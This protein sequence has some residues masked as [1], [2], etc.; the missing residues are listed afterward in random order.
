LHT[1]AAAQS[2]A[3]GINARAY[4]HRNH[5]AFAPGEYN[6]TLEGRRLM[7]HELTHTLQQS[8]AAPPVLQRR[9]IFQEFAGLFAGETFSDAELTEYLGVITETN[10]IQDYTDSDNKARALTTRLREG[11]DLFGFEDTV[12]L[13][14]LLILEMQ[15]GATLGGD[16]RS[17]LYLMTSLDA[18][19]IGQLFEGTNALS[20]DDL[21]GDIH[22]DNRETL[23]T[24]FQ[25]LGIEAEGMAVREE[26]VGC[27]AA[28]RAAIAEA[29][30]LSRA[31]IA[32]AI[33]VLNDAPESSQV[34]N[35]FFLAF[36]VEN[37]SQEQISDMVARLT[38]VRAGVGT[39]QYLCD[40]GESSSSSCNNGAAGHAS[41]GP[42]GNGV[43][44]CFMPNPGANAYNLTAETDESRKSELLT[45]EAA[46]FFLRVDDNGYFGSECV[47]T[48]FARTCLNGT[49]QNCGTSGR[50]PDERFDNAD[51]YSCFVFYLAR[52]A[53]QATETEDPLAERAE[54]YRGGGLSIDIVYPESILELALGRDVYV[55]APPR[56]EVFIVDGEP[57][58]S[59]FTHEWSVVVGTEEL[60]LTPD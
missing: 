31:D 1:D 21:R 52:L 19:Q 45:H 12:E 22:G 4:T 16:E 36:R 39:V 55:N 18:L 30:R 53:G 5:I 49:Q 58:N 43:S 15:S 44:I 37:P 2:A 33:A 54:A 23:E 41:L 29:K 10:T 51:S 20:P 6:A 48:D 17:I 14:K 56:T 35:S 24:L 46:H 26:N 40:H 60:P 32:A 27:T 9:N 11:E 7:A 28:E 50:P 8:A 57:S 47:E 25:N 59:G 34:R 38:A 42:T 3:Q 13:R